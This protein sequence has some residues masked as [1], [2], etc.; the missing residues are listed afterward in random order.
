MSVSAPRGQPDPSALLAALDARL[1]PVGLYDAPDATPFAPLVEPAPGAKRGPCVFD[2][3]RRWQAGETLHLTRENF[4]CGGAGRALVGVRTRERDD[5]IRF[6]CDDEGL[7]ATRELM[8][9]WVDTS[10]VYE[11]RCEHILIGPLHADQYAALRTV[12]FWVNP[13]QLSV[14]L[15]GAYYEHAWGDPPPVIVPFGSGCMEL[16]AT[17]D[18]LQVPQAAITATDL[19]MRDQLPR[20]V[21]G[22]TATVPMFERLCALDRRS[23]LGKSFL[24]D[25]RRSRRGGLGS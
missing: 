20:E 9:G 18:D 7:R 3:F 5:F 23:F 8:A 16:V 22:F 17:F 1:L 15:H 14:L 21:V 6:L 13:D 25:L 11:M 4:G 12:T 24:A 10:P 19:A 2:F